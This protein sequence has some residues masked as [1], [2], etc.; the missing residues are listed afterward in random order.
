MGACGEVV[1]AV[2]VKIA[3]HTTHLALIQWIE[4]NE[5]TGFHVPHENYASFQ[6]QHQVQAHLLQLSRAELTT[7]LYHMEAFITELKLCVPEVNLD[8]SRA[9]GAFCSTGHILSDDSK[10]AITYTAARVLQQRVLALPV[11][12]ISLIIKGCVVSVSINPTNGVTGVVCTRELAVYAS[13][14]IAVH[15]EGLSS[16][17]HFSIVHA[18]AVV[19]LDTS[20]SP[21]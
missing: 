1:L 21:I 10:S 9:G 17:V 5:Q 18:G 2:A 8:G 15:R 19:L 12:V 14:S 3:T 6:G 20:P 13:A 7:A 16:L 11:E 4:L